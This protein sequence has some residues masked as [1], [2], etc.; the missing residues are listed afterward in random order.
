MK[1]TLFILIFVL[2]SSWLVCQESAE[3]SGKPLNKYFHVG[4]L[5][6]IPAFDYADTDIES[7]YSGFARTGYGISFGYKE[8]LDKSPGYLHLG[9]DAIYQPTRIY[10]EAEKFFESTGDYAASRVENPAYLSFPLKAGLGLGTR[11]TKNNFYIEALVGFTFTKMLE[12]SMFI[13][14]L[15]PISGDERGTV[16]TETKWGHVVT[17]GGELGYLPNDRF[18]ISV[19][20]VQ[21]HDAA[22]DFIS[23]GVISGSDWTMHQQM[24]NLKFQFVFLKR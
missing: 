7:D 24:F 9:F 20:Y 5:V 15:M 14:Q 22:I 8:F 16:Y 3:E 23:R 1:E 18:A 10:S 11:K 13:E 6:S 12:G 2:C 17:F 4:P 21:A 19:E